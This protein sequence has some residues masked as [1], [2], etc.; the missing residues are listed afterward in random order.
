MESRTIPRIQLSQRKTSH[1]VLF[2]KI[3]ST[4]L[5]LL[6]VVTLPVWPIYQTAFVNA[7]ESA[8]KEGYSNLEKGL[9]SFE[10]DIYSLL[11]LSGIYYGESSFAKLTKLDGV[12]PSNE[13]YTLVRANEFM[14]NSA[15]SSPIVTESYM[16]FGKNDIAISRD[17]IITKL[18]DF[19]RFNHN[20]TDVGFDAWRTEIFSMPDYVNFTPSRSVNVRPNSSAAYSTA[21]VIYCVIPLPINLSASRD[22][23]M[24]A[25]IDA[26][27]LLECL[28]SEDILSD[29]FLYITNGA[30]E[31]ILRH[32]YDNT[33]L[34]AANNVEEQVVN[35]EKTTVM[36]ILMG[37]YGLTVT[38][39]FSDRL[40][41]D[42]ITGVTQLM[43]LFAT[44]YAVLGFLLSM[45]LAYRQSRP[46]NRILSTLF[47][48][49][50]KQEEKSSPRAQRGG[51][52]P[53]SGSVGKRGMMA[54]YSYIQDSILQ[55]D[56]SRRTYEQE[57]LLLNNSIQSNMVY[58]LLNGYYCTEAEKQKLISDCS[59]TAPLYT[60]AAVA[61]TGLSE[62]QSSAFSLALTDAARRHLHFPYYV[63]SHQLGRIILLLNHSETDSLR[64]ILSSF[65]QDMRRFS[66]EL[67]YIGVSQ[68]GEGIGNVGHCF[69]QASG[70][71]RRLEEGGQPAITWYHPGNAAKTGNI[72]DPSMAQA[73][74]DCII[75]GDIGQIGSIFD[76]VAEKS[77]SLSLPYC[78]SAD[79]QQ[80]FFT[81]RNALS[82]AACQLEMDAQQLWESLFWSE[83]CDWSFHLEQLK[84]TA[85][86]L[87]ER[88][89]ER[90]RNRNGQIRKAIVSYLEEN[91][92]DPDLCA[93]SVAEL[94]ELSEKY[95]F[96]IVKS[97][98]SS[99]FGEYLIG[100]RIAHAVE[101]L[102]D[103]DLSINLIH[104][105]VG[106]HSA[107]TFYKAF[108]RCHHMSP[109][110]WRDLHCSPA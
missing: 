27:A 52:A 11:E 67:L 58:R 23:V 53:A 5:I 19:Y 109:S 20:I 7:K 79:R 73:L 34:T 87:A 70:I 98:T 72:F 90:R 57:I 18:S 75:L 85:L 94:F 31:V 104:E 39:G 71:L 66:Q 91:Y 83:E 106:F 63:Y 6:L 15:F 102:R 62:E 80:L 24:L 21:S 99:T 69:T 77:D 8:V 16:L 74:C 82:N 97:E 51:G 9:M 36:S 108:K 86:F 89:L 32:N 41:A 76:M 17:R 68:P 105:Q 110:A 2:L 46:I 43:Q 13:F 95:I 84:K 26:N 88:G 29:G 78:H 59:L 3:F 92:H 10:K 22:G 61:Y 96:S 49:V 45:A 56:R 55:I 35:G 48:I 14:K 54:E 101:L 81:V 107:N 30:G 47:D 65:F 1:S 64:D 42:K 33:P 60:V 25:I 38:A 103:R 28:A 100:I 93:S 12:L 50:P 44:I 40:I 4:Y 37:G